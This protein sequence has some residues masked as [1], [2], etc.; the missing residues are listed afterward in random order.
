MS[1]PEPRFKMGDHV[2]LIATPEELEAEGI[3]ENFNEIGYVPGKFYTVLRDYPDHTPKAIYW[4]FYIKPF[5]QRWWF[6]EDCFELATPET[7]E[8]STE[9]T[10]DAYLL[11]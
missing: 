9:I 6:S 7:P 1:K 3:N 4:R 5:S 11:L 10:E 8:T 2:R